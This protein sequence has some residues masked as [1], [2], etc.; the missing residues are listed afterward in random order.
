M[1]VI[2]GKK[3]LFK[4]NVAAKV[5]ADCGSPEVDLDLPLFSVEGEFFAAVSNEGSLREQKVSIRDILF[6]YSQMSQKVLTVET[7]VDGKTCLQTY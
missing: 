2:D 6:A 3:V 7:K 4:N 1:L 5:F